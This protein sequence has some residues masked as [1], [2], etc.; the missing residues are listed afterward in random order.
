[1][2]TAFVSGMLER[3]NYY[4]KLEKEI[5]K[6]GYNISYNFEDCDVIVM[7][8]FWND[9]VQS[10]DEWKKAK[11]SNIPIFYWPLDKDKMKWFSKSQ[12]NNE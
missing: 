8:P 5:S 2:I 3:N 6:T 12:K 1:M 10:K 4:E 7:L 11:I 9:Y